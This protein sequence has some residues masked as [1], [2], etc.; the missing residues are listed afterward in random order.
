MPIIKAHTAELGLWL[1]QVVGFEAIQ[2]DIGAFRFS[3][4]PYVLGRTQI[5]NDG[6]QFDEVQGWLQANPGRHYWLSLHTHEVAP[7]CDCLETATDVLYRTYGVGGLD[8]VWVAP[9]Q[10]VLEYLV[11][12]DTLAIHEVSR[13]MAGEPP[14]GFAL[15]PPAA[16][17]TL[18]RAVFQ[19]GSLGYDGVQDTFIDQF[20]A[21]SSYGSDWGLKVRTPS[22]ISSLIRYDLGSLPQDAVVE[23]AVLRLYGIDETN[24]YALCIGA[25]PLLRPW[26]TNATWNRATPDERWGLPGASA[27]GEDRSTELAG[28]RALA[29]GKDR[30]YEIELSDAVQRWVAHPEENQGVLLLG[31][32]EVSKS[33]TLASSNHGNTEFRPTLVVT[34]TLPIGSGVV[35]PEEGDGTL[36]ARLLWAGR[37]Q[38]PAASWSVPV[39]LTLYEAG[40]NT[41]V[42]WGTTES[43]LNGE[44]AFSQLPTGTFDLVL[45]TRSALRLVL[46]GL[47]IHSG[48]N[49]LDL[50]P[51]TEGDIAHDGYIDARDWA[52]MWQAW[53]STPGLAAYNAAADLNG[54]ER[55]DDA[56]MLILQQAYGLYGDMEQVPASPPG[57]AGA[58]LRI[59]PVQARAQLGAHVTFDVML[60]AGAQAVDGADFWIEFDPSLLRVTQ[61]TPTGALPWLL[62]NECDFEG[63][64]GVLRFVAGSLGRPVSGAISLLRVT[65]EGKRT[66]APAGAIIAFSGDSEHTNYIT[67]AGYN[68]LSSTVSAKFDVEAT[69]K[70][71]LPVILKSR[72]T[73]A[74]VMNNAGMES[75]VVDLPIAGH[76]SLRPF[77][78]PTSDAGARDVRVLEGA[79]PLGAYM[80]VTTYYED[81]SRFLYR[82]DVDD[83]TDPQLQSYSSGSGFSRDP[84]EIWLEGGRA[85]VAKKTRGVD[86]LNISGPSAMEYLGTYYAEG[87]VA[88][89]AKGIHVVGERLYVADEAYGLQIIDVHNPSSPTLLGEVGNIFG[90]G[91]WCEG[92]VAYVAADYPG[93]YVV[94]VSNPRRPHLLLPEALSIPG[95]PPGRAVD[96]QVEDGLLY[97]AAE[98]RG[99]AVFDVE[100]PESARLLGTLDTGFAQKIDVLDHVVYVAD[101]A[102]GLLVVDASDPQ[103][104]RVVG[105]CDTPGRAFGVDVHDGYA[106]VADGK[107]G[108]QIVDLAHLT[109]TP[110]PTATATITPSPTATA[111]PT[112]T[113]TPTLPEFKVRL[114][115]FLR[116]SLADLS[117]VGK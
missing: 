39:T 15:P 5:L 101:D 11:T 65:F 60:D 46:R 13:N 84:D 64:D 1:I 37:E 30:W 89:I 8:N 74:P 42:W 38:P 3:G 75:G 33:V 71:H 80:V 36:M 45:D 43:G 83:P 103:N 77:P 12:R 34:Y 86:I 48:P 100:Q 95:D 44:F 68:V 14:A 99:I 16:T 97:V 116:H 27:L 23:D 55:V 18:H 98:N 69:G 92:A 10:E 107:E 108:L 29:Q 70:I 53:G 82:L 61:V 110:G 22:P 19:R 57:G 17:P 72:P 85:Y 94:D 96:V 47:P 56:D 104:M 73:G 90:E 102:G 114:P 35:E 50:G 78:M 87:P 25:Y 31:G 117:Q 112:R 111:T 26:A 115:L 21:N 20:N 109:P 106:Y 6:S 4:Q 28:M 88:P 59:N 93:V 63:Y 54:D 76:K 49:R 66:T 79:Q 62:E 24:N 91:V 113:P 40:Q 105:Q 2:A 67:S 58:V 9:A 41:P 81:E 7:V 32:G 52:A 51:L